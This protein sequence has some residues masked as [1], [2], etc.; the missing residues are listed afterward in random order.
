MAG[1]ELM[2]LTIVQLSPKPQMSKSRSNTICV[3]VGRPDHHCV[4]DLVFCFWICVS[5]L[6][7]D[8]FYKPEKY[9]V[10]FNPP[11]PLIRDPANPGVNVAETLAYWGQLRTEYG[12]WLK[13]LNIPLGNIAR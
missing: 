5:R 9:P 8:V 6:T 10:E 2:R 13:T 1:C 11:T 12:N 3:V 4:D 7:W